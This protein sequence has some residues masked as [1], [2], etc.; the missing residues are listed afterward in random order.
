MSDFEPND[1]RKEEILAK[2]RQS[3]EDEGIEHAVNK[4]L[5]L[6]NYYTEVVGVILL[7][8]CMLSGQIVTMWALL[9]L[10]GAHAFG[11]FLAKYRILKQKRYLFAGAILLGAVYGGI[12]GF[13]FLR[14]SGLLQRWWG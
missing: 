11:D 1:S 2:S 3:S 8:L 13:L 5:K 12:F 4:G 10:Y 7:I 6:G 14:D 9:T